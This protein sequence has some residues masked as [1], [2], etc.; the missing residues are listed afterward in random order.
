[1]TLWDWIAVS[2]FAVCWLAY[3]PLLHGLARDTAITRDMKVVRLA[4][5]RSMS[6]REIK[7]LDSQLLGHAI[8]SASFFASANL[9]LIA[10][11]AGA[12]F[13]GGV[14][15]SGVSELGISELGLSA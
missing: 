11:V 13:G 7:L 4:W 14:A 6:G 10:A 15:L 12:L 8:N 5:M 1:M 3:E 2:I 9:I